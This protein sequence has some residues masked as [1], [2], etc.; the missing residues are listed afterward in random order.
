MDA[1][2]VDELFAPDYVSHMVPGGREAI[3]PM[4]TMMKS[5]YPD[6][7]IHGSIEF[8]VAEG[9]YVVVRN[10][11]RLT[12][13]GKEASGSD[14]SGFR[15]ANGKIVEDWPGTGTAKSDA[16]GRRDFSIRVG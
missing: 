16:T 15:F 4:L 7:K 1:A 13:A 5:T 12:N 6:L 3:K 2:L 10:T 8:M 9:D 11:T 14:F